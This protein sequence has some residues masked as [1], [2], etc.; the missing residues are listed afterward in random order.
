MG[1]CLPRRKLNLDLVASL[2]EQRSLIRPALRLLRR[3]MIFDLVNRKE[4]TGF[5]A[6][7]KNWQELGFVMQFSRKRAIENTTSVASA[8]I[9]VLGNPVERQPLN[10]F[11]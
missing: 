5:Q 9:R 6:N 4:I 2:V 3:L 10:K 11:C 7:P 1:I 8:K